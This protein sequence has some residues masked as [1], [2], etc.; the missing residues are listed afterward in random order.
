[1]VAGLVPEMLAELVQELAG[2]VGPPLELQ[3]ERR[4]PLVVLG[5]LV[6]AGER[7]VHAVDALGGE[8]GVVELR[9]A[10]EVPPAACLVQVVVEIRA[11]R[12]EAVDVAVLD[13]VRDA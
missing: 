9:R 4:D 6:L 10:D 5:E 1:M 11:G 2:R 13:E 3:R 8:R 7:V 12:D